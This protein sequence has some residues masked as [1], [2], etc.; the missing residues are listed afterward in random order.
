MSEVDG[1][2][3][4]TNARTRRPALAQLFLLPCQLLLQAFGAVESVV[5]ACVVERLEPSADGG[6]CAA[7]FSLFGDRTDCCV[8]HPKPPRCRMPG[9]PARKPQGLTGSD[10]PSRQSTHM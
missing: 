9:S 7:K 5:E 6:E 2:P 10:I 4:V 8:G 1:A 3:G